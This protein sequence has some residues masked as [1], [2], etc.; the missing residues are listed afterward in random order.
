M[1][2]KDQ[3]D[4]DLKSAMKD[5]DQL[6]LS[7]VRMLKSAVKYREIELMK[8]LDDVGVQVVIASEVKRRRDS[9]EQYRNGGRE[10]LAG[11]EEAEIAIL[12]AYLPAQLGPEE[13]GKLVEAVIAR[14]GAQG[15]KDMGKV[16]K[17]LQPEVQGKA[18]GKVVSELVKQR[19]AKP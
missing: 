14:V 4:A 11:K 7:T 3:L 18:E 2:L 13:L 6:K 17:E 19:L 8:P 12:Q 5:K 15:P 16:M 1:A 10:D 9:V